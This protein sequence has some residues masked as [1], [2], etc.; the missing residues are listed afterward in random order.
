MFFE[1]IV[2]TYLTAKSSLPVSLKLEFNC[3]TNDY[4]RFAATF[5][6]AFPYF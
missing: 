3:F 2:N 5:L 4:F 6:P 1:T